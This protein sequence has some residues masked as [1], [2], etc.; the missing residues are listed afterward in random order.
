MHKTLFIILA[1]ILL[2]AVPASAQQVRVKADRTPLR[3][4]P[5]TA[6]A[7]VTYYQAGTKLVVIKASNGWYL[8]RDPQTKTEGY[9]RASLVEVL[10]G[11]AP[12]S[13]GPAGRAPTATPSPQGGV[14]KPAANPNQWTDRAYLAANAVYQTGTPAFSESFTYPEYVE[15]TTVTTQYPAGK[16]MAFDGGGAVRVWRNLALGVNVSVASRSTEA[17]VSGAIP[18]PFFFDRPRSISGTTPIDRTENVVHVQA[19]W[20]VPIGRRLL[21]AVGGGPSFFSVKQSLVQGVTISQ[22]Y[23]FDTATFA[24]ATVEQ[25]SASAVGFGASADVGYYFS[26]YIGVGGMVRYSRATVSVP[27]HDS[28]LSLE[29]GGFEAGLGLRVR[30]PQGK[31]AKAPAKPP[32]PPKP[33][34]K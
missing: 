11:Q 18:H 5:T 19:L 24:S 2:V 4:E 21:V 23:P 6:S 9:M 28:S 33:V 14:R 22:A 16:G 8:V 30:L 13:P 34:K 25:K 12:P 3:A 1:F 10:P 27:A 17:S 20:V 15:K 31:P 32:A 7:A 26:K 29:A